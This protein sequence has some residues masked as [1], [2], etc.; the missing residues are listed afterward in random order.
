MTIFF[1]GW[2]SIREF[3]EQGGNVLWGVFFV[4]LL[5]WT[6]IVERLWYF[7][8]QMP[9]RFEEAK[10]EW[11]KRSDRT[12]WYAKKVRQGIIS[13]FNADVSEN[14]SMVQTCVALAP[15]FGLLGTVTGM[16]QVFDVMA[17]LGTGNARAMASGVSAATLPTMSGMVVAISGIYFAQ[18]MGRTAKH[19]VEELEDELRSN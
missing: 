13:R 3:F 12:S 15:L 10:A 16:I 4:T 5:L 14:V 19:A 6:F 9:A 11:T 7:R 8:F 18:S 17:N 2:A 1:E